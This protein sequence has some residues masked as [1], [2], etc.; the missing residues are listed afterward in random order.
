DIQSIPSRS[1]ALR[2]ADGSPIT[3]KGLI[4]FDLTMGDITLP[5]E[6]FALRNLGPDLMLIENSVISAFGGILDW[7]EE[8]L[9]V[10]SST[11]RLTATH[12]RRDKKI[13]PKFSE[14]DYCSVIRV[15]SAENVP[16]YL[17]K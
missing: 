12:R 11:L 15:A 1:I 14:Y 7:Q 10:R 4:R 16:V 6:A 13:Q 2:S 3:I 9:A 17:S 5:V 8:T